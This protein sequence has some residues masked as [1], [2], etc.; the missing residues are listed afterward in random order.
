MLD[1]FEVK[2]GD[3]GQQTGVGSRGQLRR[4][5]VESRVEQ[6]DAGDVGQP[7]GGKSET[8]AIG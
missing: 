2:V 6:E 8:G 3:V 4:A 7:D 5:W 1:V